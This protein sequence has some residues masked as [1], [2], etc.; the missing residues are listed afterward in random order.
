LN[1]QIWKDWYGEKQKKPYLRQDTHE[2]KPLTDLQF[3]PYEDFLGAGL[4]DGNQSQRN[5]LI[6]SIGFSSILVPGSGEPNFDSYE[7]NIFQTK[8]QRAEDDVAKL[9]DKVKYGYNYSNSISSQLTQ[10]H[11]IQLLLE[12]SI[13][14]QKKLLQLRKKLRRKRSK[15]KRHLIRRRKI[16]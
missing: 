12:Q 1:F 3:V 13:Q 9:L 11:L 10:L 15:E 16:K 5:F 4:V 6:T 2:G 8:K 14:P 7:V